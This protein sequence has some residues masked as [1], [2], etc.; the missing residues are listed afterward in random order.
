MATIV[1]ERGE[2]ESMNYLTNYFLE[3]EPVLV[4]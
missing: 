3:R 2:G 4:H 1:E